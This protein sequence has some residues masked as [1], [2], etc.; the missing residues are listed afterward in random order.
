MYYCGETNLVNG[1]AMIEFAKRKKG[2]RSIAYFQQPRRIPRVDV[3]SKTQLDLTP[4]K[5]SS[6]TNILI[7]G[8]K[9]SESIKYVHI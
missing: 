1:F 8:C 3:A 2:Q 7:L 5:I 4:T 9:H 6:S